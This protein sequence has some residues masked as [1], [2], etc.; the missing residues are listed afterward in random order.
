MLCTQLHELHDPMSPNTADMQR[1]MAGS[2]SPKHVS[3]TWCAAGDF[4]GAALWWAA[5]RLS[6]VQPS[7][8]LTTDG[9]RGLHKKNK[10]LIDD[11]QNTFKEESSF[12]CKLLVACGAGETWPH[13]DVHVPIPHNTLDPQANSEHQT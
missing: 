10:E 5:P 11:A 9:L 12:D 6:R 1:S 8:H 13:E 2:T 4:K 3:W 7:L